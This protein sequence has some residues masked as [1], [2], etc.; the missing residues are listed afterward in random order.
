MAFR[1]AT[2]EQCSALHE[3]NGKSGADIYAVQ[4]IGDR[5]YTVCAHPI[6]R[7]GYCGKLIDVTDLPQVVICCGEDHTQ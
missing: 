7:Y 1:T 4:A 2:G 6:A 3:Y 5:R